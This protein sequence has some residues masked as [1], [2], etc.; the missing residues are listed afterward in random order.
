MKKI[1]Y[2]FIFSFLFIE[3]LFS[4]NLISENFQSW[5]NHGSYGNYT[6][7]G[8]GGVWTLTDCIVSNGAAAKDV[9]SVGR[10]Q[11][12]A[13]SGIIELP[14]INTCGAFSMNIVSGGANKTIKLQK[15]IGEAG[16]WT[17]VITFTGI[18]TTGVTKSIDI[19]ESSS[20]VYLRLSNPS[21]AVY[22]HDVIVTDYI[23]IPASKPDTP[24]FILP[25]QENTYS[26]SAVSI[27]ISGITPVNT[28]FKL[29]LNNQKVFEDTDCNSNWSTVLTIALGLKPN[30][31]NIIEITADTASNYSDTKTLYIF[32][33]TTPAI[34]IDFNIDAEKYF[35]KQPIITFTNFTDYS[36]IKNYEIYLASNADFTDNLIIINSGSNTFTTPVELSDGIWYIKVKASDNLNNISNFTETKSFVIEYIPNPAPPVITY[37]TS[38]LIFN[39]N[40]IIITGTASETNIFDTVNLYINGALFSSTIVNN[41]CQF[42]YQYTFNIQGTFIFSVEIIDTYSLLKSELASVTVKFDS[43]GPTYLNF[44]IRPTTDTQPLIDFPDFTDQ[45]SIIYDIKIC[46]LPTFDTS[47]TLSYRTDWDSSQIKIT[48]VLSIGVYYIKIIPTDIVGNSGDIYVDTFAVEYPSAVNYDKFVRVNEVYCAK[49]PSDYNKEFIELYNSSDYPVNLDNWTL[50]VKTT[51]DTLSGII[52]GKGYYVIKAN[53]SGTV[54]ETYWGRSPDKYGSFT[55]STNTTF[56]L[57]NS[58]GEIIQSLTD[59]TLQAEKNWYWDEAQNKWSSYVDGAPGTPWMAND[60]TPPGKINDLCCTTSVNISEIELSFKEVSDD[61]GNP[62]SGKVAK[63]ILKYSTSEITDTDSF[64]NAITYSETEIPI[65]WYGVIVRLSVHNLIPGKTYYFAVIAIDDAGNT[66][67]LSNVVHCAAGGNADSIPPAAITDLSAATGFNNGEIYLEWT[68]T[69]DNEIIGN[70]SALE[71]RYS[72]SIITE[73]NYSDASIVPNPPAPD[74]VGR[75]QG[76]VIT[77]LSPG[78]LYFFAMKVADAYPNFSNLSNVV[79]AIAKSGIDIIA[80]APIIDLE[81]EPDNEIMGSLNLKFTSVGDD[82]DIGTAGAYKIKY[83]K[84]IITEETFN[85]DSE[86]IN[87]F[88]PKP[89]H[90]TELLNLSNFPFGETYYFAIKVQDRAGNLSA[91]SNVLICTASTENTPPQKPT[92]LSAKSGYRYGEI[93]LTFASPYDDRQ[94]EK[95]KNYVLKYSAVPITESNWET[96]QSYLLSDMVAKNFFEPDTIIIKGFEPGTMY[97]FALKSEDEIGNLSA[98]SENVQA[99]GSSISVIINEIGGQPFKSDPTHPTYSVYEFLELYNTA[100]IDIDLTGW[101]L[102]V[103]D[104]KSDYKVIIPLSGK[105]NAGSYYV[106]AKSKNDFFSFYGFLPDISFEFALNGDEYFQLKNNLGSVVDDV[107]SLTDNYTYDRNFYLPLSKQNGYDNNFT[108]NWVEYPASSIFKYGSPKMPNEKTGDDTPPARITDLRAEPGETIGAIK[109]IWTAP[110]DDGNIGKAFTYNMRYSIFYIYDNTFDYAAELSNEP[111]PS[112][113]GTTESMTVTMTSLNQIYYFA[114]KSIDESFNGASISNVAYSAPLPDTI[115][116]DAITDLSAQSGF[117]TGQV[118]ISFTVP[119]DTGID[120]AIDTLIIAYYS[121]TITLSNWESAIKISPDYYFTGTFGSTEQLL[122]NNLPAEQNIYIAVRTKDKSGNISDISNNSFTTVCSAVDTCPP[123]KIND[124]AAVYGPVSNSIKLF[125]TAVGDNLNF[126]VADTYILKYSTSPID[127]EISFDNALRIFP[128]NFV[129]L[130][131]GERMSA[132]ITNLQSEQIYYFAIKSIDKN[133]NISE[134]SNVVSAVPTEL[135][136]YYGFLHSH[137]SYS[138]GTAS[139]ELAFEYA[140]DTAE[141]NFFAIT[142]HT[143]NNNNQPDLNGAMSDMQYQNLQNAASNFTEDGRF[144]AIAG[145]EWNA[146]SKGGHI[147]IYEANERCDVNN[148]DWDY[149][150]NIWIPQHKEIQLIQFN[151]PHFGDF[152]DVFVESLTDTLTLCEV[153][154]ADVSYSGEDY[155]GN[156]SDQS[157]VYFYLLNRGWQIA[158]TMNEDNH[159]A[160][161]GRQT[162]LYTG[163]YAPSLTKEN[164]FEAFRARRVFA[165]TDK[166]LKIFFKVNN[167]DMGQVLNNQP[168]VN[169]E[170]DISDADDIIDRI[171]IYKD[172]VSGSLPQIYKIISVNSSS[173]K[174]IISDTAFGGLSYYIVKIIEKD[175]DYGFAAPIWIQNPIES[176]TFTIIPIANIHGN[177]MNG[178]PLLDGKIVTVSGVVTVPTGMFS[179]TSNVVYIQD[180]TGAI[181]IYEENKQTFFVQEGDSVI[182]TGIVSH[183]I[184]LTE[185]L[186][187]IVTVIAHNQP[188]PEPLKL[189]TNQITKFGELYE[190][191]LIRVDNVK[192]VDGKSFPSIASGKGATIMIN[193]GSGTTYLQI[194]DDVDI[195]G[196]STP[197]G[198]FSVIGVL[199]QINLLDGPPY[200]S[201]YRIKPRRY[202]EILPGVQNSEIYTVML[203]EDTKI[204]RPGV[205]LELPSAFITGRDSIAIE[206]SEFSFPPSPP[207]HFKIIGTFYSI[208]LSDSV[209]FEKEVVINLG[210][211][212]RLMPA[213]TNESMIVPYY[214]DEISESY[215]MIAANKY[216]LDKIN[217]RVKITTNHFSGYLNMAP[218]KVIP[219]ADAKIDLNKDGVLDLKNSSVTIEGIAT[220]GV[221]TFNKTALNIYVQDTGAAINIYKNS[222]DT[223]IQVGD[224]I[225]VNGTLSQYNGLSQIINPVI[226]VI[227][228]NE[229]I[230]EAMKITAAQLSNAEAFEAKLVELVVDD[231][232]Q[233]KNYNNDKIIKVQESNNNYFI[234]LNNNTNIKSD[235][236]AEKNSVK[237]ILYQN[238]EIKRVLGSVNSEYFVMPRSEGDINSLPIAANPTDYTVSINHNPFCPEL[239]QNLEIIYNAGLNTPMEIKIFNIEGRLARDL[240]SGVVSGQGRILWDGKKNSGRTADVGIYI[241]YIKFNNQK[242]V[243]P[244]SVAVHMK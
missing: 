41:D 84:N 18:G 135:N 197:K 107:F 216:Q 1:F 201:G 26:T 120:I 217:S 48:D 34:V 116:P 219:I 25:T 20:E 93:I 114:L 152:G 199:E 98:I 207:K 23:S 147:N 123:A 22:V 115:P 57:K 223:E 225:C 180:G 43:A 171:E 24:S 132:I 27:T 124:L 17:D 224:R 83:S 55:L 155:K 87:N 67:V 200:N 182:V 38:N 140:R 168:N 110:G 188:Q 80:P 68:N 13:T 238:N 235:S 206:I 189:T 169:M 192:I 229:T 122:L 100:D 47:I 11:M 141:L 162:S 203:N 108:T 240:Y 45:N 236:I 112:M 97:Y 148:G 156:Y 37:P 186:D 184:G 33:D 218:S 212:T 50:K 86:Y 187:P 77:D 76:Y 193:D 226:E 42:S 78:Q 10:I 5:T 61:S 29:Y 19:N 128:D 102:I 143:R 170:L 241:L 94:T 149:L 88:I 190:C 4:V 64:Y 53:R 46:P 175:G 39:T 243:K 81:F 136:L 127:N 191:Q 104:A 159:N 63:Y 74:A 208:K 7:V 204:E 16:V 233:I 239:N 153:T 160:N 40:P 35:I 8:S 242:I 228:K 126:G 172:K 6:Q 75:K 237:G 202:A 109:L 158:P 60:I 79:S 227:N 30:D 145:Q 101:T 15:K 3:Y 129:S 174:N 65:V 154:E 133:G 164:L 111:I 72:G 215:Y 163:V 173:Y 157:D 137:S 54:F 177:D 234:Y 179:K 95:V 69:G 119:F 146:I 59:D 32:I 231:T 106:I 194:D 150:Y 49:S 105:I 12:K 89:S 96:A 198:A 131:S 58:N 51:T 222:I 92:N 209:P 244:V 211:D 166:T 14:K 167:Y 36:G 21:A 230:P 71:I 85:T 2:L 220:V 125:W 183:Y 232:I 90:Q 52:P 185:L 9:C 31:T 205:S 130:P 113:N 176:D 210:Y 103:N 165:T 213:G 91:L 178:V 62:N 28:N 161:W 82:T 56:E 44:K 121:E 117:E 151:H 99:E 195:T 138:D 221:N 139:P 142:D 73:E 118:L 134:I 214:Y 181:N 196:K 144:I 66:S 70:A